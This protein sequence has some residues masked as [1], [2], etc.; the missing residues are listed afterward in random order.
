MT[1]VCKFGGTSMATAEAMKQSA[2]IVLSDPAR[3]YVVV[4]APGK[5]SK[6]D[7][8]IT[9]LLY[10]C[11]GR[12]KETGSCADVFEKVAERYIEI[13]AELGLTVDIR[14][15]LDAVK[16]E[17]E[18]G[19]GADYAASRGEYLCALIFAELISYKFVD[20]ARLISF[21]DDGAFDSE[22]TNDKAGDILKGERAVIPGFYGCMPDGGIKTFPR[23]GSDI[24]G[25]IV[26]RAVKAAVYENW[27]DVSGFMACDP[28]IVD[29]P[30]R[31]DI[32]TYRELR[33]LSYMGAEVLH[34][35]SIFPV[36][37][38]DIPINIKNTFAPDDAGTMI[39]PF[40]TYQRTGNVVTGIA[41]RKN[42]IAVHMEKSMMNAD[43]G[44]A[45][46]ALTVFEHFGISLEH[47]PSG[48]DTMTFI[49]DPATV[50]KEQLPL[51]LDALNAALEPSVLETDD[52]L[53]LIAT[54]GHGM[55]K[56]PG[57][58]A[59]LFAALAKADVNVRM[60]DQG[61][62]EL[63]IIIGVDN[64]DFEKAIRTIYTAFA[65]K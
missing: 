52:S 40:K 28:R 4:S 49:L 51:V 31:I 39:V 32:L 24:S 46:R 6:S 15:K 8:K 12:A 33:E 29:D 11:A 30:R 23:G 27:T 58:A 1:K 9:D 44:F 47:M 38:A 45:R 41:G 50:D 16:R 18:A 26:A 34:P 48:I 61:S 3:A 53:A 54:V 22:F 43:L 21:F 37:K 55:S 36:R 10:K 20:A 14:K 17:I 64:A 5:R 19:A 63:N 59:A 57:T 25:A 42:F 2:G 62:S 35:D 13:V 60:I 65:K 56:R 7:E